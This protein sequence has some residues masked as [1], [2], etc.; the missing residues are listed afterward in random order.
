MAKDFFKSLEKELQEGITEIL[1]HPF[2]KRLEDNW[3][4]KKQLVYFA[5]QYS[6]YC[7]YFPRFLAAAAANIP[8]DHQISSDSF[9]S[10]C[11][12]FGA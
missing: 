10:L 4:N 12:F 5:E 6:V 3:F 2:L 9:Q 1:T 7:R 11:R 8:D